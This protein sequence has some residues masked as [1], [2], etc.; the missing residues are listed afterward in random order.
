MRLFYDLPEHQG[1]GYHILPPNSGMSN[2]RTRL[3]AAIDHPL[4]RSS[5]MSCCTSLITSLWN[6]WFKVVKDKLTPLDSPDYHVR[7]AQEGEDEDYSRYHTGTRYRTSYRMDGHGP[8]VLNRTK[9][10][11]KTEPLP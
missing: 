9:T 6:H 2:P 8:S 1:N 4:D 5:S 11:T 10:L 3:I 7:G